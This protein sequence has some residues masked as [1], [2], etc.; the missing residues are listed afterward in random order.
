MRLM[1]W[2][3]GTSLPKLETPGE[4]CRWADRKM[5]GA[6]EVSEFMV[7]AHG[8]VG[9]RTC[10]IQALNI[11]HSASSS[12]FFPCL[13][14]QSAFLLASQA[15][16]VLGFSSLSSS[17]LGGDGDVGMV[18]Q[19]LHSWIQ[20]WKGGLGKG[21]IFLSSTLHIITTNIYIGEMENDPLWGTGCRAGSCI[22]L[23]QMFVLSKLLV[24]HGEHLH[25]LL[26]VFP[27]CWMMELSS[28]LNLPGQC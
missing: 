28:R 14:H 26:E 25:W 22:G 19:S 3:S 27:P 17:V 5:P 4:V 11:V 16:L 10:A 8:D 24:V 13:S 21:G 15:L 20:R 6:G 23:M 2:S 1:V 9:G 12:H 18:P 7:G